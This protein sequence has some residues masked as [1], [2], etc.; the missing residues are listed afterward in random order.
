MH[1]EILRLH[2]RV[3]AVALVVASPVHGELIRQRFLPGLVQAGKRHPHWADVLPGLVHHFRRTEWE[4]EGEYLS[5]G[6]DLAIGPEALLDHGFIAPE[7][8]RN[9]TRRWWNMPVENGGL[10]AEEAIRCPIGHCD[11][12]IAP[13]DANELG[14]NFV[15]ARCEHGAK[16]RIDN[17]KFAV[18]EG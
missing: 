13:A 7:H 14:H 12:T 4:V 15:G 2:N 11:Q 17:V 9:K 5:T 3:V 10:L 16:H 6:F 1:L 8:G 18:A